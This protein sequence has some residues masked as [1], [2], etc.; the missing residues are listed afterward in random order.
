MSK[1]IHSQK[2]QNQPLETITILTKA[3][4]RLLY[5]ILT[6]IDEKMIIHKKFGFNISKCHHIFCTTTYDYF[7]FKSLL[8]SFK[9]SR[10]IKGA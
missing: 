4:T 10:I 3:E 9:N 1:S 5:S 8:D 2:T 7:N 6:K